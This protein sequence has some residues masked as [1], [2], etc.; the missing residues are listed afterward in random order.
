MLFLVCEN[1]TGLQRRGFSR[2]TIE[3]IHKALR[4]LTR[5]HLNTSQALERVREDVP[6]LPEIDELVRFI[7]SSERGFVK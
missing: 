1:L 6:R 5:S 2:E 3:A 4:L 7:E